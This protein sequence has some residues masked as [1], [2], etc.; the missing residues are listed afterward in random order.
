MIRRDKGIKIVNKKI[1]NKY[2]Y[3]SDSESL[4]KASVSLECVVK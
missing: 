1:I 3:E 4:V 2:G